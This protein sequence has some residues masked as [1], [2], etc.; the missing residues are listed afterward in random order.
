[1][2]GGAAGAGVDPAG[3]EGAG[4]GWIDFSGAGSADPGAL[5]GFGVGVELAVVVDPGPVGGVGRSFV[6]ISAT[7]WAQGSAACKIH[8]D[9]SKQCIMIPKKSILLWK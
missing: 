7:H 2:E 6:H 3:A 4:G 8:T 5:P 1:M 9:F